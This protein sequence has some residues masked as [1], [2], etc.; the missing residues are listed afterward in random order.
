[1]V[2]INLKGREVPLEYSTY[3]MKVIQERF[4]KSI[5]E[6]VDLLL[7]RK[8]DDPKGKLSK[9]GD[10]DHLDAI[11]KMVTILGNAGLEENGQDPNLTEKKVL[12]AIKPDEIG[13]MMN[14]CLDAMAKGSESEIPEKKKTGPVDVV[15]EEI[16]KKKERDG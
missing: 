10:A 13:E 15:L 8:K 3:E 16:E 4:G 6:A 1:M 14:A 5:G 11:A 12:R 9:F 2:T 7:G